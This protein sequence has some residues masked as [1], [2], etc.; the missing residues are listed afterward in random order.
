MSEGDSTARSRG[1]KKTGELRFCNKEM[2]LGRAS[3]LARLASMNIEDSTSISRMDMGSIDVP[4]LFFR[5]R[6]VPQEV[7]AR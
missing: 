1:K 2:P 7:Q 6:D 4:F 5:L 3:I